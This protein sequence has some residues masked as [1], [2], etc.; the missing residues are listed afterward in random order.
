[1]RTKRTAVEIAI[2]IERA[3]KR[4][5]LLKKQEREATKAEIAKEREELIKAVY[6][7]VET[8]PRFANGYSN[9]ELIKLVTTTSST[10][11]LQWA[12]IR[13][14]YCLRQKAGCCKRVTGPL[15]SGTIL[16]FP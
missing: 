12:L 5:D 8:V 1:M 2:Q 16:F 10:G 14:D 13:A 6:E 7:W 15:Q 9:S 11:G 3:Q 4:I